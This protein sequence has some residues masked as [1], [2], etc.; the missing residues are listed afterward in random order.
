MNNAH[1]ILFVDD[2][3]DT[4]EVMQMLLPCHGFNVN[5]AAN[6]EEAKRTITDYRLVVLDYDLGGGPTGLD[7]AAFYKASRPQGL[8]LLITGH[9]L[10][11]VGPNVDFVIIKPLIIENFFELLT[12][13]F[14]TGSFLLKTG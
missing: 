7:L 3:R 5:V 6:F 4:R 14:N 8:V 13:G 2:E 9:Q 1:N 11:C 12:R 10:P